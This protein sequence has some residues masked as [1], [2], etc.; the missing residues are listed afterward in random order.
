MY[1]ENS[2]KYKVKQSKNSKFTP[3]YKASS[4]DFVLPQIA[5]IFQTV[6]LMS[7]LNYIYGLRDQSFKQCC[8]GF[9]TTINLSSCLHHM[10][11]EKVT[12]IAFQSK[13][14][15]AIRVAFVRA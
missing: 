3:N 11:L 1:L 10:M 2:L 12:E 14:T 4:I 15:K 13:Q 5:L 6:Y 9:F 8:L 7:W